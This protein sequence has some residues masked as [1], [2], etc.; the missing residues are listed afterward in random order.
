MGIVAF[1]MDGPVA[2]GSSHSPAAGSDVGVDLWIPGVRLHPVSSTG[3]C[4]CTRL[5]TVA[6][7]A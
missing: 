4:I 3:A 7:A 5:D 6:L 1:L 2:H